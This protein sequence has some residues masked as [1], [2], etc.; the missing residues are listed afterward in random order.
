[1]TDTVKWTLIRSDFG[2]NYIYFLAI[3]MLST[4]YV[5]MLY[6]I[7]ILAVGVRQLR[8]SKG[9]AEKKSRHSGKSQPKISVIIPVKNEEKVVGRLLKALMRI[10]YPP[11]K[12]EI[13]IVEDGSAD[14]TVEI[15]SEYA[16]HYPSQVKLLRKENSD[17]KPSA[18]NYA[19]QHAVGE[20]V[21]VFDADSIP[22]QDLLL[23]VVAYFDD[24]SVAAVQGRNCSINADENMLA[25][26][27]SYEEAVQ[28]EAYIRGKDAIGLF[29][30]LT[31][32]CYFVRKSVLEEVGGW[33]DKALSEDMEL[34]ARLTGK[35]YRIKYA[36]DV[37]SWQES[38]SQL[39]LLFRQ[40][41]RWFRGTMEVGL[42]YGGLVRKLD[43]RCFDAEVTFAG[44]YLF[45]PCF[46]GYFISLYSLF[47]PFQSD[48]LSVVLANT[49]SLLTLFL[50]S[51][52]G[53]A[54]IFVAKPWKI[55]NL[56]WL[57]FIYA[58]WSIQNF[59]VLYA[60]AQIV[61][62]RPRIWVKTEKKG[63]ISNHEFK[64]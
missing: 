7:P 16:Q 55:G 48:V 6:N 54:L 44:P 39:R 41:L 51:V 31:G 53:L 12:K 26:F 58:Y 43:R 45:I 10:D 13:I 14:R 46:L 21:G 20:I 24:P 38:P 35:G 29:V 4:L 25:K 32:S 61:F 49:A 30:P 8:R 5:W 9:K 3:I 57:P 52:A 36:E 1:M 33:D 27:V 15:C 59:I 19:L 62:R 42:K 2:L 40:R 28:Y 50:L 56:L 64:G 23:R 47:V 60:L 37:R 22:E 17:G 11:E 63:I 34:A 18:L